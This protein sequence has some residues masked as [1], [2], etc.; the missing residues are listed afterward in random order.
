MPKISGSTFESLLPDTQIAVAPSPVLTGGS[1]DYYKVRISKPTNA[2]HAPYDAECNDII[3]ALKMTFAE[4]NAF[5]AIWRTASSRL[6]NGKP[7]NTA[8]YDAEKVEWFGGRM[9]AQAKADAA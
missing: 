5:K 6:G 7:G 9:V 4:G 2:S 8:L 1:S 3:E